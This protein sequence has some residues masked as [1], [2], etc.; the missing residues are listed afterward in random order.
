MRSPAFARGAADV[1]EGRPPRFDLDRWG[2]ERGRQWATAAPP[3]MPIRTGRKINPQ[4]IAVFKKA[5]IP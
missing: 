2:Y 4:A 3:T 5:R 1:R